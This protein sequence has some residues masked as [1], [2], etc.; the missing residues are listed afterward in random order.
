MQAQLTGVDFEADIDGTL[1]PLH[2]ASIK[3][4]SI[5]FQGSSFQAQIQPQMDSIGINSH[6]WFLSENTGIS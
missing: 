5:K 2:I 4:L 1:T 3:I 6:F